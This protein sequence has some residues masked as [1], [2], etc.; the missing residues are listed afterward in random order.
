[1]LN[2]IFL[3]TKPNFG[4]DN[5]GLV[6][7]KSS[8]VPLNIEF[9]LQINILDCGLSVKSQL[10]SSAKLNYWELVVPHEICFDI[11]NEISSTILRMVLRDKKI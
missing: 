8:S 9:T 11:S 3:R 2:Y 6:S 10:S 7:P 1:M 4:V 5:L